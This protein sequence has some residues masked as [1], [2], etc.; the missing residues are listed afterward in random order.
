MF[1]PH[2][3]LSDTSSDPKSFDDSSNSFGTF[4]GKEFLAELDRIAPIQAFDA[5]PKVSLGR[6]R[7]FSSDGDCEV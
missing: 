7:F 6:M 3:G 1:E 4:D 5:F 2:L